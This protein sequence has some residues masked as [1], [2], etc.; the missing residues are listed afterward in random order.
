MG[1]VVLASDP[2]LGRDVAI[3]EGIYDLGRRVY[4]LR[5]D[6]HPER[7]AVE[8]LAAAGEPDRAVAL[9]R[10]ARSEVLR[11]G[12]WIHVAPGLRYLR[13]HGVFDAL[14]APVG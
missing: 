7:W 8:I 5:G 2:L 6:L 9:L 12:G 13:G 11:Y 3:R 10:E 4:G 14:L 1:R